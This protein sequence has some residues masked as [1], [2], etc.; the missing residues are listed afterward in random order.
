MLATLGL[1]A[2]S[3]MQ[4]GGRL[5]SLRRA[6]VTETGRRPVGGGIAPRRELSGEHNPIHTLW[7]RA[8][9]SGIPSPPAPAAPRL[10]LPRPPGAGGGRAG[11]PRDRRA[12]SVPFAPPAAS[13]GSRGAAHP[14]WRGRSRPGTGCSR[15]RGYL[16]LGGGRG[17]GPGRGRRRRAGDGGGRSARRAGER[18][19][20]GRLGPELAASRRLRGRI[21]T[22]RGPGSRERGSRR[23]HRPHRRPQGA[24]PAG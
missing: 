7:A 20:L 3:G 12:R 15:C 14:G 13:R 24:K 19:R 10:L 23:P 4:A 1:A 16:H 18:G 17:G 6:E 11:D 8:A 9:S 21:N 22:S 2:G 5:A